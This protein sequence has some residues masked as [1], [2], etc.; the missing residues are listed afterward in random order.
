M[1][2]QRLPGIAPARPRAG[3]RASARPHR[4]GGSHRLAVRLAG[5]L[6]LLAAVALLAGIVSGRISLPAA[7]A[8]FD[9]PFD[10]GVTSGDGTWTAEV[11]TDVLNVRD[12]AS[13]EAAVIGSLAEGQRV[14]VTGGN[15]DGFVPVTASVGG[16]ETRGWVASSYLQPVSGS[17]WAFDPDHGADLAGGTASGA[18]SAGDADPEDAAAVAAIPTAASPTEEPTAV[19][20]SAPTGEHWIDVDRTAAVVT[21][22]VGETPVAQ[23]SAL[24]GR[25]PSPDGFYATAV[26]TFHVFSMDAALSSTPF[27][28][29]V[30]L[31]DWVG[32]DPVRKN[33][34]HSPVRN[35]DGSVRV[36]GGTV[37]MGCVRLSE[38]DA[39]AL[40]AFAEIGMRVEVHD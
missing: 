3:G 29:D 36:T 9:G 5:G 10:G 39:K 7:L 28:D 6:V 31:T 4:P 37:T 13:L 32:F 12:S 22:F 1:E 16:A 17:G 8:G 11:A 34:F 24:I 35:A 20:T 40:Y 14:T 27:V 18:D 19:P 2:T 21:L 26:G 23:F 30:Y 15:I 25:D 38:D 33:G